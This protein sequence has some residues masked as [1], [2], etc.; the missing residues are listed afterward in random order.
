MN[1]EYEVIIKFFN[2]LTLD[3]ANHFTCDLWTD[4]FIYK[5][6]FYTGGSTL[7]NKAEF[8]IG[9]QEEIH[10]FKDQLL[11]RL[12]PFLKSLNEPYKVSYFNLFEW[13]YS[14]NVN[15]EKPSF[16]RRVKIN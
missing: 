6:N 10:G 14:K 1:I 2:K 8:I 4:Q 7:K 12:V 5:N 15:F 11:D 16:I 13:D 3:Q 9:S